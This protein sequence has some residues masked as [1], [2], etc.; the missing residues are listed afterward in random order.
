MLI[1]L[2]DDL[3]PLQRRHLSTQAS[4]VFTIRLLAVSA[5]LIAMAFQPLGLA[6][7]QQDTLRTIVSDDFTKNRPK[8]PRK[9]ARKSGKVAGNEFSNRRSYRLASPSSARHATEINFSGGSQLGVTLWK[10]RHEQAAESRPR[11]PLGYEL[12]EPSGWI[13]ERVEADSEFHEGEYLRLSIESPRAG[14]LYVI[15]RDWLTHG[16]EG[17]TNLIF[18]VRGDDNRLLAGRLIDVPAQNQAPFKATPKPNQ[19]GEI[20]TIIVTSSPLGLAIS[21][22]PLPISNTQLVAWEKMWGGVAERFELENGTG[23]VR[24]TEE[25]QAAAPRGIR[26]LTRDDPPPQTIYVLATRNGSAFLLNVKLSYTR[27]ISSIF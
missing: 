16:N 10:L 20:L 4:Q 24:T 12:G 18:P 1:E 17:E 26:Q 13:A 5:I 9:A 22:K 21:D 27:Q 25:Q 11:R 3:M 19:L 6:S 23:Q 7:P 8:A 14:Y 15:D 2:W